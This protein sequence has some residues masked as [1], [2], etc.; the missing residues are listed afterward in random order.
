[1]RLANP[2]F[3]AAPKVPGGAK[4]DEGTL[5]PMGKRWWFITGSNDAPLH[6]G[7]G[8]ITG[9]SETRGLSDFNSAGAALDTVN[10]FPNLTLEFSTIAGSVNSGSKGSSFWTGGEILFGFK[11]HSV[12]YYAGRQGAGGFHPKGRIVISPTKLP[13]E[14][15]TGVG[16]PS[17]ALR[18]RLG[19]ARLDE[20]AVNMDAW[21]EWVRQAFR[22]Y[23]AAMV[24]HIAAARV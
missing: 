1:M 15:R 12:G 14:L 13:G 22:G 16:Q 5:D 19:N 18:S 11:P 20:F 24:K 17:A 3:A 23:N 8:S 10:L 9:A 6:P 21:R 4:W 2:G 7:W